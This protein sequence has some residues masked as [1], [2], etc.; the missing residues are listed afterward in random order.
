MTWKHLI[1]SAI[2]LIVGLF[3]AVLVMD[4][5]GWLT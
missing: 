5:W 4:P 2:G 1:A 3:L